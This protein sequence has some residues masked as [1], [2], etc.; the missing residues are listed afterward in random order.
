MT[1][2]M[3]FVLSPVTHHRTRNNPLISLIVPVY[4]EAAT[5][6]IFVSALEDLAQRQNFCFEYVFVNDGSRDETLS[7]LL[8]LKGSVTHLRILNFS[9]NFGKEAALTAGLDHAR[10]DVCIPIDVDLQD[11]PELITEFVR[12]WRQGFDVVYGVRTSRQTD[13]AM[14]RSSSNSFYR[15]FNSVSNIQIPFNAGDFRLMDRRVVTALQQ[16][17]ERNR[18]MKGLFA[19]VGFPT[20]AVP[21]ARPPRSAGVTKFNSRKLWNF[22]LDGLFSF[23]SMPL[24]IW[25]YVGLSIAFLSLS[26]GLYIVART[27]F[28]GSDVPGYASIMVVLLLSSGIQLLSIGIL[29]EYVSRLFVESKMRPI[30][31]VADDFDYEPASLENADSILA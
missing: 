3:S 20:A 29:G 11:P 24:K 21:Y 15:V 5:I 14:K 9:R 23:S 28:L 27:L 25:T 18:F 1:E 6:A 17:P 31:I 4:N 22:A 30:Y 12:L 10:G 16:L 8:A 19:W 7:K 26:Y 2:P 13:S